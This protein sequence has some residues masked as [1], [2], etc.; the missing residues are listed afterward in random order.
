LFPSV[1]GRGQESEF[2]SAF[3]LLPSAFPVN[4]I[5]K[6]EVADSKKR[7]KLYRTLLKVIV[8]KVVPDR[9][10]RT[11]ARVQKRR[12]KAYPFMTKPRHQLR[13]QLQ[14]A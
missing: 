10:A 6:F 4:F 9:P 12:P 1:T 14:S 3:C 7:L 8:H 11:E 13:K 5:P 2:P